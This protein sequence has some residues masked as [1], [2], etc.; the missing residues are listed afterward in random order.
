MDDLEEYEKEY[1]EV[2]RLMDEFQKKDLPNIFSK[3]VFKK[4]IQS[5]AG[6][7]SERR[8]NGADAAKRSHEKE[9]E[10][11]QA[12]RA[13]LNKTEEGAS[14]RELLEEQVKEFKNIQDKEELKQKLIK[15]LTVV[16]PVRTEAD[17]RNDYKSLHRCLDRKLFLLVKQDDQWILPIEEYRKKDDS[18]RNV[19]L[20][21][22]VDCSKMC[23]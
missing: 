18:M 11:N 9:E 22:T 12:D 1:Y 19:N 17:K 13:I 5:K 14:L 16:A 2:K 10:T 20:N 3:Y 23:F 4:I 21:V 6:K 8:E 15:N 7:S